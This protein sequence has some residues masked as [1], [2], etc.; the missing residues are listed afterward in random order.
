MD[1]FF[2]R[3][4]GLL[5]ADAL[6]RIRAMRVAVV[7]VGGV[8]GWCAEALVRSG[9]GHLTIVD[10]D[11]VQPSNVNRQVMATA[12][13]LGR[14]KVDVLAE[15]LRE[16]NPDAEIAPL[17]ARYGEETADSFGLEG[18][19]CVVDAIDDLAAKAHLVNSVT[20]MDRPFIV[21][22]MG[23]ARRTD[24]FQVRASEFWKVSGDGLARALRGRFRKSG[25]F[26]AK[27]FKCVW[28]GEAPRGDGTLMQVTAAFG[29]ALASLVLNPE[30]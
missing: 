5:G 12:A 1:G 29:L 13:T 15:R 24:P 3:V 27:K 16:I 26:P 23:A 18:F 17:R 9:V 4:G 14:P 2:E 10:S 21:S 25:I 22:S 20:R 11:E 8:G 7:G 19:D 28:S 6:R 30:R